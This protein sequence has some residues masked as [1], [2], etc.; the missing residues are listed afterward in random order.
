VEYSYSLEND[1]AS[2]GPSSL[3]S[4]ISSLITSKTSNIEDEGFQTLDAIHN[5]MQSSMFDA[6][7]PVNPVTSFGPGTLR[8]QV[9]L[10]F[11]WYP[12]ASLAKYWTVRFERI[13]QSK[14]AG[15]IATSFLGHLIEYENNNGHQRRLGLGLL[16]MK[17]L[18]EEYLCESQ[19]TG[20][21]FV[22]ITMPF[23]VCSWKSSGQSYSDDVEEV[24]SLIIACRTLKDSSDPHT[25]MVSSEDYRNLLFGTLDACVWFGIVAV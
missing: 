19:S 20:T 14:H 7:E 2:I 25:Q 6:G 22:S 11:F 12:L 1:G 9:I 23:C 13:K 18:L 16:L 21:K 4:D 17:F 15:L 3:I 24:E 10:N 8:A 5:A